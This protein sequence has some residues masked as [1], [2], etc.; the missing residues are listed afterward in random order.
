MK[1][2][3]LYLRENLVEEEI[4]EVKWDE[5]PV[6][7]VTTIGDNED[8]WYK[9]LKIGGEFYSVSMSQGDKYA[10][11]KMDYYNCGEDIECL[12]DVYE[13]NIVCPVCGCVETDCF[14]YTED[15][16]EEHICGNCGSVLSWEREYT[17]NYIVKAKKIN[18]VK[19]IV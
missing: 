6:F 16:C 19:K 15:E 7:T 9:P 12:E 1:K 18:E 2:V 5:S 3:K 10:V 14:E 4:C 8:L 13:G 11:S 17:V